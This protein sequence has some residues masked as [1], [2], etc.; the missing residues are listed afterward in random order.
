MVSDC[1]SELQLDYVQLIAA[2]LFQIAGSSESTVNQG[3]GS[4]LEIGLTS[5]VYSVSDHVR[6]S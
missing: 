5:G 3:V 6:M 4:E 2:A 1:L